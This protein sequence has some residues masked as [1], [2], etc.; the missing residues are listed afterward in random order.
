MLLVASYIFYGSWS[1]PCLALIFAISSSDYLIARSIARSNNARSRRALLVCSI[2]LDLGSLCFFKYTNFLIGTGTSIIGLLGFETSPLFFHILLPVGISFFTFQSM[3]YTIDVYRKELP[4]CQ[5][6][7]DYLLFVSFFPQLVAGPIVRA[8]EFIPQLSVRQRATTR[9]IESGLAL[10]GLGVIKKSVLSDQISGHV[11]LVFADPGSFTATTL[12]LA[13]AGYAV[14]IYCDFSGYTD[15]AIG[16]ARM[17]GYQ[18]NAN[19]RMPYA[20]LSIAEFWR[21]WHISLSTWL[22]DYLYIPL[23][24]N[25]GGEFRTYRNL[26]LTMLLGG[27]W[28]GAAWNF[29]IWGAIHGAALTIQ[30]W[31]RSQTQIKV[32]TPLGWI[33]TLGVV[34]VGWI[35]FRSQGLTNAWTYLIRLFT[36]QKDGIS[37]LSPQTLAAIVVV[38]FAHTVASKDKDWSQTIVQASFAMRTLTYTLLLIIIVTLASS[39]ANPFIYFQF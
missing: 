35:F 19:F 4:P 17:M 13:L 7:R 34:L 33:L 32:P 28:H 39:T 20:S 38:A 31:L 5:C 11:D 37:S 22:R 24:G 36:W 29:V 23:G 27:V 16:I 8:A 3:S 30:R 12:L 15:M 2:A 6:Y 10:F 21:R 9:E 25:R 14:Q 1:V 26:I 18:F